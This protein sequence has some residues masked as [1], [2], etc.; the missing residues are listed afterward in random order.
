MYTILKIINS[1]NPCATAANPQ[2]LQSP[3]RHPVIPTT[4]ALCFL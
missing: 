2:W 1:P 4:P 3:V